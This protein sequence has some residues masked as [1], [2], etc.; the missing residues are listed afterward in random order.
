MAP[1]DLNLKKSWHPGLMKNR[2]KVWEMEQ[3]ALSERKKI[4]ERQEEIR[5]ER[6]LKELRDL[7]FKQ[8]GKK[9]KDR[10]DWMYESA[11]AAGNDEAVAPNDSEEYLLGNKRVDDLIVK[12]KVPEKKHGFE[13]L[14]GGSLLSQRDEMIKMKDDPILKIKQQQLAKMQELREKKLQDDSSKDRDRRDRHRSHHS[15]RSTSDHDRRHHSSSQRHR[16][17]DRDRSHRS[18]SDRDRYRDRDD[19]YSRSRHTSSRTHDHRRDGYHYSHRDNRASKRDE[20]SRRPEIK[21]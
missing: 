16:D 12:A 17:S 14:E 9:V 20:S 3:E 15:K 18:S 11:G 2:K 4:Q 8:T 13:K 1:G 21:Q 7:Q 6:E 19:D 10:V 5:K